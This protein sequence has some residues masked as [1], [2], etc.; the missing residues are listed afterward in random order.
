MKTG[1]PDRFERMVEAE[2]QKWLKGSQNDG[3]ISIPLNLLRKEHKAI[4][5]M[6]QKERREL[7]VLH[8]KMAGSDEPLDK[9]LADGVEMRVMGC[10]DILVKLKRRA[11]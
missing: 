2:F 10:E 4:V 5:R 7:D 8:K 1:R 9:R 6:V 3:W 11:I